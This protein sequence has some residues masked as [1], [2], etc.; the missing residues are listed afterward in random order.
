MKHGAKGLG[1]CMKNDV[2]QKA[3]T[4]APDLS[5]YSTSHDKTNRR[6]KIKSL[7]MQI[8]QEYQPEKLILFG[9]KD[10]IT[11]CRLVRRII[12]QAFGLSV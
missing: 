9:S 5:W 3:L 10:A 4:R 8:A 1:E 6:A 11:D 2:C 12:R 7:V